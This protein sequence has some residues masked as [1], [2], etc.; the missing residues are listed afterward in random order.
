MGQTAQ[1][2]GIIF[3]Q[4]PS[5]WPVEGQDLVIEDRPFD[6]DTEPP[7]NG[8]TT[9]NYYF[10][11]DPY[12]RGRMRKPE[13]KSYVPAYKLGKVIDNGAVAKVLKSNNSKFKAGDIVTGQLPIEE[14]SAVAGELVNN[15]VFDIKN[16]YGLDPKL[17]IGALGE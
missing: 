7:E 8:I 17:F 5:G 1:N 14:Y 2:K 12:Q 13:I 4:I 10:S 11:L 3:K 6:L 15:L 16:P 9:K